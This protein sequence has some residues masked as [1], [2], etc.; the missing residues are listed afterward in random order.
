MKKNFRNMTDINCTIKVWAVE[1]AT[2]FRG[3]ESCGSFKIKSI[4]S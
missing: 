4:E 2:G 1:T 3:D